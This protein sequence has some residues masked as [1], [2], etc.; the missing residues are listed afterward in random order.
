MNT[1]ISHQQR[2]GRR[3]LFTPSNPHFFKV[4]R[5]ASLEKLKL[6]IPESFVRKYGTYLQQK[7]VVL[8]VP[9][10]RKWKV[11]LSKCDGDVSLQHGWR[12]FTDYYSIDRHYFLSFKYEKDF[13]Y[14]SVLIFDPTATEIEYPYSE[15]EECVEFVGE[16]VACRKRKDKSPV[17][18]SPPLKL[19]RTIETEEQ[20]NCTRKT[21]KGKSY[22]TAIKKVGATSSVSRSMQ[23]PRECEKKD[24]CFQ[25][26]TSYIS[27]SNKPVFMVSLCPSYVIHDSNPGLYVP[28]SFSHKHFVGQQGTVFLD[29]ADSTWVARYRLEAS[30][31][32]ICRGWLAFVKDNHLKAGDICVME[33]DNKKKRNGISLDVS[34]FRLDEVGN[35]WGSEKSPG[36]IIKSEINDGNSDSV[37]T[38]SPKKCRKSSMRSSSTLNRVEVAIAAKK[39]CDFK[40]Q[41]PFFVIVMQPSYVTGRGRLTPTLIVLPLEVFVDDLRVKDL[42]SAEEIVWDAYKLNDLFT[43]L[44]PQFIKQHLN[45]KHSQVSLIVSNGRKWTIPIVSNG[46]KLCKFG[47]KWMAF[48]KENN[49]KVRD[50]CV[51]EL[52]DGLKNSFRVFIRRSDENENENCSLSP[53]VKVTEET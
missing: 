43:C 19:K 48:A 40:L 8:R 13:F 50:A 23:Q 16:N 9:S 22:S 26:A 11:E 17:L 6:M 30:R 15:D 52:I 37:P 44:P 46:R 53:E 51:F 10:G 24:I 39:A 3:L 28:K 34:I 27:K 33:L 45:R 32:A 2:D 41:N 12:E 36:I 20:P 29:Y 4:I 7:S 47:N 5:N 49:L 21:I 25:R 14:F 1:P 42:F 38:Q 31:G 18:N 35:C